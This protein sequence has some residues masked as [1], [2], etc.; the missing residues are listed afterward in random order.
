PEQPLPGR[1]SPPPPLWPPL[2]AAA[3]Q[4][5]GAE[6]NPHRSGQPRAGSVAAAPQIALRCVRRRAP[7]VF[8]PIARQVPLSAGRLPRRAQNPAA[9]QASER[10]AARDAK[11]P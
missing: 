2:A 3:E 8:A 10:A 6:P 9:S 4:Q 7:C 1:Q 11:S 5:A